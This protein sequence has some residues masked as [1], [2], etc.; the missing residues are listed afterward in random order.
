MYRQKISTAQNMGRPVA[1]KNKVPLAQWAKWSN[2]ARAAFNKL[3]DTMR[4]T[5]QWIFTHPEMLPLPKEHWKTIRWNTS[6]VAADI[7]DNK[8]GRLSGVVIQGRTYTRPPKVKREQKSRRLKTGS[9][10]AVP[11]KR[12]P[13]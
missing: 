1:N 5:M 2:Q 7:V 11:R 3:Y 4:P 12:I 13:R 8:R 10:A 9:R 6:W